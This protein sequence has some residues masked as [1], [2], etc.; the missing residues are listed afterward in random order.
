[1]QV[2]VNGIPLTYNLQGSFQSAKPAFAHLIRCLHDGKLCR[3]AR[4]GSG[5]VRPGNT[6]SLS[7]KSGDLCCSGHANIDGLAS[8][9][10]HG[11]MRWIPRPSKSLVLRV[12]R[13]RSC[14]I[15]VAAIRPSIDDRPRRFRFAAPMRSPQP[16]ATRSSTD[17]T[18]MKE[19]S[20]SS[21]FNHLR[22]RAPGRGFVNSDKTFVSSTSLTAAGQGAR[23]VDARHQGRRPA[24]VT[25]SRPRRTCPFVR[26]SAAI[27]RQRRQRRSA[28]RG[29]LSFAA[30]TARGR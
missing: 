16:I 28:C 25:P 10:P 4:Y 20:S 22:T 11:S 29:V 8:H 12:A 18:G 5:R 23:R 2:A 13:A 26:S 21:S 24:M 6:H 17:T 15:A 14:A 9:A 30:G 27:P 3:C 1:M 19:R 7:F